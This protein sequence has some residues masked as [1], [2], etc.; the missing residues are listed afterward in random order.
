MFM[1]LPLLWSLILFK[2]VSTTFSPN[3]H[4]FNAYGLKIAA[5]N[6]MIVEVFNG[7]SCF[8]FQFAPFTDN[9]TQN[10]DRRC[11]Y[12]YNKSDYIYTVALDKNQSTYS[13]FFVG[14]RIGLD[15]NQPEERRMLV[16]SFRYTGSTDRIDCAD[17]IMKKTYMNRTSVHQEYLVIATDPLRSIVYGFS[18]DLMFSY[19]LWTERLNFS[20]SNLFSM[21]TPFYPFAVDYDGNR[22]IISGFVDNGNNTRMY[23]KRNQNKR[24]SFHFVI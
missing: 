13:V 18:K 21:S 23:K 3:T 15:K 2:C 19:E 24:H 14:E 12:Y 6:L 1:L 7:V 16:G 11:L 20:L 10:A 17:L 5:N 8:L 22:G 9:T 4:D